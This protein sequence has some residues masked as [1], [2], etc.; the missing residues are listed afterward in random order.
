M[1]R[2]LKPYPKY[3]DSGVNLLGKI[4]EH[5]ELRQLRHVLRPNE[6]RN[7]A[8][9][10]LLSVTRERGVIV[11]N[12]AD[13]TGNHNYIPDDLTNYKVVRAGQ[14]VMN[15]MKAW[16]GSYGVSRHNGIV[17]PAYYVF[18]ILGLDG[19]YFHRAIRSQAY[20]PSFSGASDGIRVGQWDLS[21]ARMKEIPFAIPPLSEQLAIA[22]FLASMDRRIGRYVWSLQKMI[23][24]LEESEQ[25]TITR[26]V[27]RG[28]EPDVRLRPSGLVWAGEIPEHWEVRKLRS[29]FRAHGSGTTPSEEGY[30]GGGIPW[31]VSGDLNDG[32]VSSTTRTVSQAAVNSISALK[33]WSPGSLIVAMY[34]ATI[35]K[36]GVLGVEA[37]ANQACCVLSQPR[38][39][40]N[41]VFVQYVVRA[42]RAE[43]VASSYGGGQP[44]I[45]AEVVMALRVPLPPRDEQDKISENIGHR[46]ADIDRSIKATVQKVDLLRQYHARLIADV[47]TG[48]LDVREAAA[49][50]SDEPDEPDEPDWEDGA[51][52][53][54]PITDEE[55]P[56]E[57]SGEEVPEQQVWARKEV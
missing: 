19:G 8:D 32:V 53:S 11:R 33:V 52:E 50:V 24:L 46:C 25:A 22:R 34:G 57:G 27:A 7:R 13:D 43:L 38:A 48:K 2:G 16:Q 54:E 36:T 42:A 44:N 35:G 49:Q 21:R 29:L 5:W 18:D 47:V 14:F 55:D 31:V 51:E 17:S 1:I 4:P 12:V 10:P 6:T 3:K 15:K 45:N 28:L 9:L 41:P 40:V 37:C 26:T 23:A 20:V 39:S 56:P 30:Y